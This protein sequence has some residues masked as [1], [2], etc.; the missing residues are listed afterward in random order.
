MVEAGADNHPLD[1][2]VFKLKNVFDSGSGPHNKW[3]SFTD[4]HLRYRAVYKEEDAAPWKFY[5]IEGRPNIYKVKQ[6]YPN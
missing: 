3:L 5:K 6:M 1:G 4:A 2:K